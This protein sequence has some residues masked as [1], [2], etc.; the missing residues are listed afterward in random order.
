MRAGCEGAVF[1]PNSLQACCNPDPNLCN[2]LIFSFYVLS[3]YLLIAD[4][5]T[6]TVKEE[7]GKVNYV[8]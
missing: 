7:T 1:M 3:I 2:E 5:L 4:N 8:F 6:D